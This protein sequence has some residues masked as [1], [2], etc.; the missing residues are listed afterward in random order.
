MACT[1]SGGGGGS[2]EPPGDGWPLAVV[3]HVTGGES[4]RRPG[5]SQDAGL[6]H[7]TNGDF[8]WSQVDSLEGKKL[9]E[10]VVFTFLRFVFHFIIQ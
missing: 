5:A 1:G 10:E 6:R 2:Q 4:R 7:W 9:L 3:S 8:T